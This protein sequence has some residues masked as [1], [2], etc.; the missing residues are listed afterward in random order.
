MKEIKEMTYRL[1]YSNNQKRFFLN[2]NRRCRENTNGYITIFE[3]ITDV[4]FAIFEEYLLTMREKAEWSN[5]FVKDSA[6][7]IT[8]FTRNL[9]N[10]N[11]SF[12]KL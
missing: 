3:N 9:L 2:Y 8:R 11:I 6:I 7:F 5:N 4:E 12:S 1:E 10:R